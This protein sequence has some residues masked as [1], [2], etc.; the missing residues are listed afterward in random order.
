MIGDGA[1]TID[2]GEPATATGD[3]LAVLGTAGDDTLDVIVTGT[4]ITGA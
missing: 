1:D 4:T 3:T 2:G